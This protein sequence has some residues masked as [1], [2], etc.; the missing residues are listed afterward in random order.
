MQV[1]FLPSSDQCVQFYKGV[2]ENLIHHSQSL[3]SFRF[4]L[5]ADLYTALQA[6]ITSNCRIV[7]PNTS[8]YNTVQ[9]WWSF[10]SFTSILNVD[11]LREIIIIIII[12]I[13]I[14]IISHTGYLE[15]MFLYF[16]VSW[17]ELKLLAAVNW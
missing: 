7:K 12:I 4:L 8:I 14:I 16:P 5:L 17:R 15:V 6:F 13:N 3:K 11:T 10:Y 2:T 1:T 9:G